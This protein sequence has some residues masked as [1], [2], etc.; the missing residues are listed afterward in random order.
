MSNMS[1]GQRFLTFRRLVMPALIG[2]KDE[3]FSGCQMFKGLVQLV[4]DQSIR[5][6]AFDGIGI[7][8]TVKQIQN[9]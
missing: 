3:F 4:G 7:D 6:M 8:F 5:W 2:V 1:V 9:R